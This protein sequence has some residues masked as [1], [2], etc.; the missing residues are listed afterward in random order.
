[1]K[2]ICSPCRAGGHRA[3]VREEE[4]MTDEHETVGLCLEH[5]IAV[6]GQIRSQ[7]GGSLGR[8]HASP[9][10]HPSERR[11]SPR[12]QVSW[13]VRLWVGHEALSGQVVD[14]SA[15][16]I[17]LA[18]APTAAVKLGK[19]YRVEVLGGSHGASAFI[20]EVRNVGGGRV[21]MEIRNV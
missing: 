4:P 10:G 7:L 5:S 21:G 14:A 20:A 15:S 2:I 8:Q 3:I 6:L 18:T 16:G 9:R 13:P 1:M 11:R 17:A 12:T 19:A